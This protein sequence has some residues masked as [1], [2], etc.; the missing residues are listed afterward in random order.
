MIIAPIA[1]LAGAVDKP[2]A[3]QPL[4]PPMPC[5]CEKPEEF[6]KFGC[7]SSQTKWVKSDKKWTLEMKLW[8]ETWA[9]VFVPLKIEEIQAEG[10]AIK[11]V[12]VGGRGIN[13][14]LM[15]KPGV[16]QASLEFSILC[17]GA[18]ISIKVSLELSN[19]PKANK[20]ISVK[21]D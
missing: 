2:L 10:I 5:S 3:K 14:M 20:S 7:L 11:D 4:L 8:M 16:K 21:I 9:M 15:P 1:F 19:P 12:N 13:F 18:P 17:Y 6:L